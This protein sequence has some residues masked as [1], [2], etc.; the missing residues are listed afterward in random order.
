MSYLG[1]VGD[2]GLFFIW[3]NFKYVSYEWLF[4]FQIDFMCFLMGYSG[5]VYV[6][7]LRRLKEVLFWN[8]DIFEM[9]LFY[10]KVEVGF[11]EKCFEV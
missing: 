1:C 9:W 7:F 4:F 5:K 6:V 2:I 10:K 8:M 3:R 11:L